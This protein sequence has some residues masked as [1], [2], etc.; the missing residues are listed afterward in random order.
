MLLAEIIKEHLPLRYTCNRTA[1]WLLEREEFSRFADSTVAH[2]HN[3]VESN[4]TRLLKSGPNR[5]VFRVH[6]PAEYSSVSSVI[7]KSF[8]M[9][10][11]KQK[12]FRY[13]RY[14]PAETANLLIASQRM[15]PVPHVHGYGWIREHG[16]VSNT[17][18][19]MEDLNRHHSIRD[20][21]GAGDTAK[22]DRTE[23]LQRTGRLLRRLYQGKCNHIDISDRSILLDA[24]NEDDR[25]I[26]LHYVNYLKRPSLTVLMFNLAYLGNSIADRVNEKM[27][28]DWV[29]GML[30]ELAV[31]EIDHWITVYEEFRHKRLSRRERLSI[32]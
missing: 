5:L 14:G 23:V 28:E 20:L 16:L 22:A 17:L 24:D 26:D 18:I 32:T 25:V 15:I 9:H 7:V 4:T 2:I 29:K 10:G 6:L 21:L 12:L 31:S 19:M 1:T 27:L 11:F 13:Q 30:A 8:P 3:F